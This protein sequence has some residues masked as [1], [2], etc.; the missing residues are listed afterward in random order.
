MQNFVT[1]ILMGEVYEERNRSESR[2][3][4][5]QTRDGQ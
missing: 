1:R 2:S 4:E 5:I 3:R